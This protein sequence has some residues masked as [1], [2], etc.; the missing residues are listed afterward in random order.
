MLTDQTTQN[1]SKFIAKIQ[2]W[3]LEETSKFADH[4]FN[5]HKKK[6]IELVESKTNLDSISCEHS[7]GGDL[8][9]MIQMFKSLKKTK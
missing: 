4:L 1:N 7:G 5:D 2:E 9:F 3:T 6:L 8:Y